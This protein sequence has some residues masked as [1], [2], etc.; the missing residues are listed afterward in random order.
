MVHVAAA[1]PAYSLANDSTYYGV[2][3]DITVEPLPIGCGRIVVPRRPGLGVEGDPE[4]I[5]RYA[6]D[7]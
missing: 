2:E 5:A 3:R 4:Q 1:C 7:C 6:V